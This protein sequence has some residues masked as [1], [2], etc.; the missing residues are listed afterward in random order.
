M[1][2]FQWRNIFCYFYIMSENAFR[3]VQVEKK[4]SLVSQDKAVTKK[5][6][7]LTNYI[8]KFIESIFPDQKLL[9]KSAVELLY[10]LF[11]VTK[12]PKGKT[13]RLQVSHALRENKLNMIHYE[14]V[15]KDILSESDKIRI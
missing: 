13:Q 10:F 9:S 12:R 8:F 1:S 2:K 11:A 14:M 4:W 5:P 7:G 3:V 15:P 6:T